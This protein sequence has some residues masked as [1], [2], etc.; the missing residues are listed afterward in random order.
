MKVLIVDDSQPKQQA[1]AGVLAGRSAEWRLVIVSNANDA[2]R[3]LSQ[4]RYDLLLLDINLPR[5]ADGPPE[6]DGGLEVVRWLRGRGRAYRPHYIVGMT[7]HDE[8]FNIASDEIRNHIWRVVRVDIAANSWRDELNQTLSDLEAYSL[9]PFRSD[10][11][12]HHADVLVVAALESPELSEILALPAGFEP[13]AVEHDSSRYFR[14]RLTRDRTSVDIIAVAASDKGMSG[15]SIAATKGIQ[16]FWPR[17]V[18]MPGITAGLKGRTAIGDVIFAEL[19]WDWG[20]GKIKTVDGQEE[21]HPAPYQRRLDES[22]LQAARELSRDSM[23]LAEAW[24]KSPWAK[25]APIPGIRVGVMASGGSVVQSSSAVARILDQH[26]DLLAIEMEAFSVMFACQ[27]A[28]MPRPHAI[29][30]KSV[31]DNGDEHKDDRFQ[32]AAAFAS[33]VTFSEYALRYLGTPD[34]DF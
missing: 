5:R 27:A 22:L 6:M 14:G 4:C 28:P 12:S 15:A 19:A 21:F 11:R 16:A 2:K 8:A 33:A 9:A 29:V 3:A 7:A 31:C 24:T 30:A 34:D 20:S 23:F 32:Q 13:V 10:G 17:Y 26:K 25:L 18:Y 1:I